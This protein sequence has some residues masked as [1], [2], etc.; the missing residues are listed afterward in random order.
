MSTR[1]VQ[2][3]SLPGITSMCASGLELM[4]CTPKGVQRFDVSRILEV[5]TI[6]V[7]F[8]SPARLNP[9][10]VWHRD[11]YRPTATR[12]Q[13]R[14]YSESIR[15]KSG[16]GQDV[17]ERD[18]FQNIVCGPRHALGHT[19]S[20]RCFA[21]GMDSVGQL[22]LGTGY[23]YPQT[24][25]KKVEDPSHV[26]FEPYRQTRK[27]P[28]KESL[29]KVLQVTTGRGHSGALVADLNDLFHMPS[30][31]PTMGPVRYW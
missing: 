9:T 14:T 6:D 11:S 22:G 23:P 10:S 5:D 18:S 1:Q 8:D 26:L 30:S 13:K 27:T 15:E 24:G 19:R 31:H 12:G 16:F 4:V 2:D 7:V 20:G 3:L 17:C 21:W 29:M 28:G 25:R